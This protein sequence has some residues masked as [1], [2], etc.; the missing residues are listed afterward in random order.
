MSSGKKSK[1]SSESDD[2]AQQKMIE[3]ARMMG[4]E[5]FEQA[6]LQARKVCFKAMKKKVLKRDLEEEKPAKKSVKEREEE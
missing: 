6:V 3:L 1:D 5:E 4:E 2:D